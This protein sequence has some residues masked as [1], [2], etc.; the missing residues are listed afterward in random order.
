[1]NS[2]GILF[3]IYRH[4]T[5]PV[6]NYNY[7]PHK[8]VILLLSRF[9]LPKLHEE[10]PS[11]ISYEQLQPKLLLPTRPSATKHSP[12]R[13]L[14]ASVGGVEPCVYLS[15]VFVVVFMFPSSPCESLHFISLQKHTCICN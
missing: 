5:Q 9:V 4:G 7:A 3:T 2:K 10:E 15:C 12:N 14:L 8:R 13:P 6:R 1:V 11:V